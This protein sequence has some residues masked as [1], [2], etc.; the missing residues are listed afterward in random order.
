MMIVM[1]YEQQEWLFYTSLWWSGDWKRLN[2][3]TNL[4]IIM[5]KTW[6]INFGKTNSIIEHLEWGKMWWMTRIILIIPNVALPS[7]VCGFSFFKC[8]MRVRFF[9]AELYCTYI[10]SIEEQHDNHIHH[11]NINLI[12]NLTLKNINENYYYIW[13]IKDV[14]GCSVKMMTIKNV[15][16][17]LTDPHEYNISFTRTHR[18][19]RPLY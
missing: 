5:K 2:D 4:V 9:K 8:T 13:L 10:D 14:H 15:L 1:R 17:G 16:L 7:R 6:R 18:K 19:L 11:D 12:W 3:V